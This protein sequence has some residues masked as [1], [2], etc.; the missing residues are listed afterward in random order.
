MAVQGIFASDSN[1]PGSKKG[2]LASGLLQTEQTGDAPLFAL[3]SGM[4]S[5]DASDVIV[6]WFEENPLTGRA[7]IT[8][9]AT[10]G[11]TLIVADATELVAGC[12]CLI[13]TTGEYVFVQSISSNTLTVT[14]GFGST[15]VTSID[16]SGTNIGLQ[17]IGNANEEG[18]SKGTSLANLGAPRFNYMQIFR[19]P[20]DVTRTA[21]QIDYHTGDI[22]AKNKQDAALLHAADI[23]RSLMFGVMAVGVMNGK[24]FRTMKGITKQLSTNVTA[25]PDAN[26]TSWAQLDAFLQNVFSRNIKGKPN[27][28]LVWCGNTVVNAIQQI[29]RLNSTT[30]IMPGVKKFGMNVREWETPFGTINLMTHPMF[31]Q[32]PLWTQDLLIVHPGAIRTRYLS[33]TFEDAYDKN[34]TRAGVDGDFG[35]WTTEMSVEYKAEATGGYYS[36]ITKGKADA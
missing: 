13:E 15:T 34:G 17:R 16:G 27:E 11:A 6:S 24:P 14:R 28:R 20:W 19:T 26:G 22:V 3:T 1:I 5:A 8:N 12:V 32:S 7:L 33:R 9:N 31:N 36:G 35:I 10:T 30:Q 25:Q 2:D 21:R 18:S 4:N 29:A 23:E